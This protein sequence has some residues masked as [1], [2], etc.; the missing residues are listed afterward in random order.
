MVLQSPHHHCRTAPP[1]EGC[2]DLSL[3][4]LS[5]Q[6]AARVSDDVD[7]NRAS[8]Q[9]FSGSTSYSHKP[10]PHLLV[11][12]FTLYLTF[13]CNIAWDCSVRASGKKYAQ[14][15][16]VSSGLQDLSG[17][18]FLIHMFSLSPPLPGASTDL[19]VQQG[20]SHRPQRSLASSI[21]A[22]GLYTISLK[23]GKY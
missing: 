6:L 3:F 20:G 8:V 10:N 13:L 18:S 9:S 23:T 22:I 5:L 4:F 2:R 14:V 21:V 15:S 12:T 11:E 19:G 16:Q 17:G 7:G 1:G